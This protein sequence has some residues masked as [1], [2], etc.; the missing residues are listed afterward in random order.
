MNSFKRNTP[1]VAKIA[2]MSWGGKVQ[3]PL[4]I[5]T[6]SLSKAINA[7]APYLYIN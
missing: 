1:N 3:T 5:I 6:F 2:L 4:K 7:S